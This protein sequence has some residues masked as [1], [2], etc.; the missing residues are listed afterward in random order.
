MKTAEGRN[1]ELFFFEITGVTL[2]SAV[3]N[4]WMND[5]LE[6]LFF[7]NESN[8]IAIESIDTVRLVG[9]FST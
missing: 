1:L 2:S 3:W 8:P 7:F 5:Y 9:H 6:V 4:E